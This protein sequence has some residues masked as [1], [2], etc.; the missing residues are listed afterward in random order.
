MSPSDSMKRPNFS[1]SSKRG[2]NKSSENIE[3]GN[4]IILLNQVTYVERFSKTQYYLMK[5]S[6]MS[7]MLGNRI[8][9]NSEIY[10]D[11]KNSKIGI[12]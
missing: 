6:R 1:K 4:L 8:F 2:N 11:C 12:Q 7:G 10:I 5:F 9:L 3:F